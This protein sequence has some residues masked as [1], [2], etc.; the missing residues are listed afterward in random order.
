MK[1]KISRLLGVGLSLVLL[2]SLMVMGTPA[3][4]LDIPETD[5]YFL[6][7]AGTKILDMAVSGDIIYAATDNGTHGVLYKSTDGGRT[8]E[9][10]ETDSGGRIEQVA[11]ATDD[12]DYVITSFADHHI[13]YSDDGGAG[14]DELDAPDPIT[15]HYDL[16]ISHD[17]DKLAMAGVNGTQAELWIMGTGLGDT[18]EAKS[19]EEGFNTSHNGTYAVQF[20]PNFE[21]D[22][23]VIVVTGS[24]TEAR[25]QV[26]REETDE[27][28]GEITFYEEADWGSGATTGG[29]EI[30][31]LTDEA[32]SGGL[33]AAS[34]ALEPDYV[35]SDEESR[36]AFVGISTGTDGG[37]A[38]RLVDAYLKLFESWSAGDEGNINS[39]AYHEAGKLLAGD[40]DS[41]QIY[42]TTDPMASDPQFERLD[43]LKQPGGADTGAKVNVA[44]AGD[45]AVAASQGDESAF[46]ASTDD[47]DSWNDISMIDT[48]LESLDDVAVSSDA[49]IVYLSSHNGTNLSLWRF[50]DD[51]DAWQRVFWKSGAGTGEVLLIRLAP[52][53]PDAVYISLKTTLDM[54]VSKNGGLT[55][56]KP[57][58]QYKLDNAV[59]DFA[60][61]SAD[62]VY[63]ID[64]NEC[65]KTD[66]AG[67]SWDGA[68]S[69]DGIT[70]AQ[71]IIV[72]P[73]GD[74]L[75]GGMGDVAFSKDGGE[76]FTR[77]TDTTDD[78]PVHIAVDPDYA[79]NNIFYI[80]A[81]DEFEQGWADEDEGFDSREPDSVGDDGFEV[82]GIHQYQNVTYILT[83]DNTTGTTGNSRLY[84][85]LAFKDADTADLA[86]WS[87]YDL[88]EVV[89]NST[90]SA[91]KF[92]NS[93]EPT[94]WMIDVAE[95][96][97]EDQEDICFWAPTL[98]TPADDTTIKVNPGSGEAYNVTFIWE[99]FDDEDITGMDLEIATDV[100]FD[101]IVYTGSFTN[102][103]TLTV[104]KV[105]GPTGPS[106]TPS[107]VAQ[108]NPGNTYYWRVRV[109]ETTPAYSPW[110]TPRSFTIEGAVSFR[111]ASPAVGAT[112]VPIMPTLTWNAY[113]DAVKYYVEI[114]EDPTFAIWDSMY[115]TESAFV[116][117]TEALDYY[118]T[119]YWRVRAVT[120]DGM[121][122]AVTEGVFTT[123][124]APV[125][126]EPPVVI[127][128]SPPTDI[129]IVEVPI[130]QP[131]AIP[132]YL[133]WVIIAIGAV[134]IIALIVLIVRTRR[135]A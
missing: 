65:S 44:W 112:N 61:E 103:D 49:M 115:T 89:F 38:V 93:A 9:A 54:W 134:L 51:D 24:D 48:T 117:A 100:D 19:G 80:G 95:M 124:A 76:I 42:Y 77:I 40:Y 39:V 113:E 90:P 123:E 59:V 1:K 110:T 91:L 131:T 31:S 79:D 20:S 28:N 29:I 133:L 46:S 99:K 8:W 88:E 26:F 53:D 4:A 33:V 121:E 122:P 34:I 66:S 3:S 50:A 81:G 126:A 16:A 120:A 60:V 35:G 92:S 36:I 94:A 111:V 37:G 47:G 130:P 22:G 58:S 63:A 74:I 116:K 83:T 109:S 57:I 69:L 52:E 78:A 119:Y 72:A 102:I 45:T 14:W 62:V 118:T 105:I 114:G 104:A 129:K 84:R 96:G 11:L 21:T 106:G 87:Y 101:G 13:E 125:K 41:C 5:N 6:V 86:L 27:W 75:V 107:Q 82:T 127:E 7:P 70:D 30:G 56:W 2:C 71:T 97:L 108:F 43:S 10:L 68:E 135:I 15:D 98:K 85:A 64:A 73:N 55:Q 12:P 132:S 32:I 25:V 18:W 17:A 67:Q 23:M 128:P